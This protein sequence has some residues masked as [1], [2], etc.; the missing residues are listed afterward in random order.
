MS[1]TF[2]HVDASVSKSGPVPFESTA[3]Q[4]SHVSYST[5]DRMHCAASTLHK[6]RMAA[7][8]R[9]VALAEIQIGRLR[10]PECATAAPQRLPTRLILDGQMN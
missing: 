6:T 8:G 5:A 9:M 4:R 3:S 10:I 1:S 7:G 2:S